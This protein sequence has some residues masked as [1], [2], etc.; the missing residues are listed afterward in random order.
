MGLG[1]EGGKD[2]AEEWRVCGGNKW[3]YVEY[4]GG[5]DGVL[6]KGL[7]KG[8]REVEKKERRSWER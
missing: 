3:M 4:R 8:G 1:V 7:N 2:R 6:W 5:K